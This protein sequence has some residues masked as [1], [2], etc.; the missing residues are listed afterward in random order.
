MTSQIF[1]STHSCTGY[2]SGEEMG[3]GIWYEHV[4]NMDDNNAGVWL[5][6]VREE[7]NDGVRRGV[8]IQAVRITASRVIN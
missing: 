2:T 7:V 3:R 6:E 4:L 8:K 1:L 5:E